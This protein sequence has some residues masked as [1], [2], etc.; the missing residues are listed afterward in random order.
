M[1]KAIYIKGIKEINNFFTRLSN[2]HV[3]EYAAMCAYFTFLSFIPFIILLL[4]LIKY[5]N[6]E[7]DTLVYVLEAVLPT[8]TKNSVLDIIQET[9]SKSI[10]VVSISAIFTLWSAAKSFYTL[11]LGISSIYHA[12]NAKNYFFLRLKG[13]VGT[14][15]I[16]SIIMVLILLVFG[17]NINS[18]IT[19]KFEGF[20]NISN[21]I[22]SIRS[23]IVIVSLFFIF[24]LIYRF[25][26]GKE[27]E[28]IKNQIPG[29]IFTSVGW[30]VVS[31]FF[32]IY[33]DIFTDF[34]VVYGSLATITLI[35]MWL[36][37]IIY[38]ILLGAEINV[39][40]EEKMEVVKK[41]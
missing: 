37:T 3:G 35:L 7:R 41:E 10:Q 23:I 25:V 38:I 32:S 27:G 14:I 28:R 24:L 12:K 40:I 4:S 22:L 18:I 39:I 30:F 9:Y 16:L 34:S 15:T 26:P 11:S 6:I 13:I 1:K 5:M 2:D 8:M 19:E 36:Y 20:S 33:V 21:F 29:A 17:N 31:F